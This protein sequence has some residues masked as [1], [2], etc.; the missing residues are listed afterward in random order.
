MS[1]PSPTAVC[2]PTFPSPRF[3]LVAPQA[4]A[5]CG[6]CGRAG[7][8]LGL[9]ESPAGL[10]TL[11]LEKPAAAEPASPG[12]ERGGEPEIWLSLQETRVG[13]WQGSGR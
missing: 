8:L 1:A 2:R 6:G 11:H 10:A 3:F 5:D 7:L 13:T 12:E 4:L 9:G